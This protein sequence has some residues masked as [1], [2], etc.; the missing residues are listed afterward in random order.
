MDELKTFYELQDNE[1]EEQ[2]IKAY[3]KLTLTNEKYKLLK[4]EYKNIM[5]NNYNIA[6]IIGGDIEDR[7]LSNEECKI[8]F[9]LTRLYYDMQ[10]IEEKEAFFRGARENYLYLKKLGI[11][12]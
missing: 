2:L 3:N 7:T 9:R 10:S 6:C 12:E 8:L 4:E 1:L 11:I 5:N